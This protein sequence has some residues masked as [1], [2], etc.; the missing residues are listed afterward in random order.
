MLSQDLVIYDM[1]V[2]PIVVIE[3]QAIFWVVV[4]FICDCLGMG[5]L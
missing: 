4:Q 1:F 3:G 2:D 5:L